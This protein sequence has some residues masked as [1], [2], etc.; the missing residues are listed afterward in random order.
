MDYYSEELIALHELRNAAYHEAGHKAIC[1]RFGGA[2]DAVVRQNKNRT[3]DEAAWRGQFRM[4]ISPDAMHS[5]WS[6]SGIKVD[7]LPANWNVL[8]GMAGLLGGDSSWR[9]R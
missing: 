5:G 7:P 4:R 8:F 3:P 2:G 9:H 6:A 1:E